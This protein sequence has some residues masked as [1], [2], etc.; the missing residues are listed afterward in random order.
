MDVLN[1]T[2]TEIVYRIASRVPKIRIVNLNA[3]PE[4]YSRVTLADRKR[5]RKATIRTTPQMCA[6]FVQLTVASNAI[7]LGKIANIAAQDSNRFRSGI[8]FSVSRTA[9]W[10][11]VTFKINREVAENVRKIALSVTLTPD[12]ALN[13]TNTLN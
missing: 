11:R 1:V 13:A 12:S 4:K 8:R 6:H 9:R 2:P 7:Q 5:A 10:L 3:S